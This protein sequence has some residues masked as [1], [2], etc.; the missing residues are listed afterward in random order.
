MLAPARLLEGEREKRKEGGNVGGTEERM[1]RDKIGGRDDEKEG[2]WKG[3]WG[4]GCGM[5]GEGKGGGKKTETHFQLSPSP[6]PATALYRT[7]LPI[8]PAVTLPAGL[9]FPDVKWGHIFGL[10][11][12]KSPY[13]LPTKQL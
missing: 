3:G 1:K 11:G 7:D 2:E 5:R 9:W 8:S 13:S 6:Q 12:T 4:G 10:R